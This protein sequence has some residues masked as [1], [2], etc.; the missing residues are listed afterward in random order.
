MFLEDCFFAGEYQTLIVAVGA[1]I[2]I[3]AVHSL[4]HKLQNYQFYIY[5]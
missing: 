5:I 1:T 2:I 4:S 3:C